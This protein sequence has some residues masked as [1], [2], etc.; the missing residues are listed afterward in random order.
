MNRRSF[1]S[2]L[3]AG[4]VVTASLS[5]TGGSMA[6]A[7]DRQS[8]PAAPGALNTEITVFRSPDC[9]CCSRW[10]AHMEAAGFQIQDTITEDM[11]AIKDQYGVPDRLASCHT[12]IADGYVLEGH[13]PA[14]DVQRLL[15]TRPAVVGL[16]APGMPMGS[17]GMETDSKAEPY[18]VFSFTASGATAP[19]SEHS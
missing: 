6:Q 8:L 7:L 18:T 15:A 10:I 9:H 11:A 1:T 12:A 14:A 3:F 17:P 19:F 13:V 5:L 2:G 16:A 4:G